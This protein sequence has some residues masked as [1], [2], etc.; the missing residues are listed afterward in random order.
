[1]SGG[2]GKK[3]S[4]IDLIGFSIWKVLESRFYSRSTWP[5]V[6]RAFSM[7]L[8]KRMENSW[9]LAN[10][11]EAKTKRFPCVYPNTWKMHVEQLAM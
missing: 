3:Y 6:P 10:Y 8:D 11:N 5:N 2:W 4:G 1:M 7:R 9:F